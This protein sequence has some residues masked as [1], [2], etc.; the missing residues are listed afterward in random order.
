MNNPEKY[1]TGSEKAKDKVE[2]AK[3]T[4]EKMKSVLDEDTI[5]NF[6]KAINKYRS[7]L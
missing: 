6:E 4:F 3:R 2:D 5:N 1:A 7:S